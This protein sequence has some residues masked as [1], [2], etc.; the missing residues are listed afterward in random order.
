HDQINVHVVSPQQNAQL[1]STA[2][3]IELKFSQQMD[4][5][6]VAVQVQPATQVK[7][8]WQGNT[9]KITPV[10]G[11]QG[12]TQYTVHVG[13]GAQTAAHQPVG[14]IQP[15]TFSTGPTPTPTPSAGPTPT[16]QPTPVLNPHAIAPIG[17]VRAHWSSDGSGL[18]VIGPNGQLQLWPVAG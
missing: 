17:G 18:L 7:T 3:P 13:A 1:V 5:S 15:V 6:S 16:P 11:L 14:R 2:A 8:E 10:Y 12:N 9:L 4:T